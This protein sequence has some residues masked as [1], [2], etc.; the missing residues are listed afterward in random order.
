MQARKRVKEEGKEGI[1]SREGREGQDEGGEEVSFSAY[2]FEEVV[3]K[4][5]T[6]YI[7][8][9]IAKELARLFFKHGV[10]IPSRTSRDLFR[11]FRRLIVQNVCDQITKVS[12]TSTGL[13]RY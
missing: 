2:S 12:A 4:P 11:S 1:E 8:S 7:R 9:A 10:T 6:S 5:A 3:I 13:K